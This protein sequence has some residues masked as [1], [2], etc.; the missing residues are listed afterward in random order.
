MNVILFRALKNAN[1][2]D[3]D[4]GRVVNALERHI[5]LAV[6]D[7][8]KALEGKLDGVKASIDG[9]KFYLQIMTGVV[10][11][12]AVIGTALTAYSQLLK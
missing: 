10:A 5:D 1:V 12:C 6:G 3:D 8:N 7:A 4:A 9:L 2:S 11:T